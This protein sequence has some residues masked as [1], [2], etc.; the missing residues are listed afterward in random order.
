LALNSVF[1][2]PILLHRR[3][4]FH[5]RPVNKAFSAL[6][7]VLILLAVVSCSPIVH[8]CIWSITL[9]TR[10]RCRLRE[11]V[12]AVLSSL[13]E[14]SRAAV[15]ARKLSSGSRIIPGDWGKVGPGWLARP[16]SSRSASCGGGGRIHQFLWHVRACQLREARNLAI[17]DDKKPFRVESS[18]SGEFRA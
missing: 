15:I 8:R 13:K 11:M 9:C 2:K 5:D 17:R 1:A 16:L 7:K 12:Y 6:R 10:F 3:D 4:F 18:S 14:L